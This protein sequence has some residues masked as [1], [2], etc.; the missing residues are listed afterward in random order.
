MPVV[1]VKVTI[2]APTVPLKVVPPEC[3]MVR[4][5]TFDTEEPVISAPAT[6]PVANVR[7]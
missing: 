1:L 5:P 4:V 7:P 2:V 6:P 3:V